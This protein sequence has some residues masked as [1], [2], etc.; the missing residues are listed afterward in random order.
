MEAYF[1]IG[2]ESCGEYE[3]KRSRFLAVAVPCSSEEEVSAKLSE[4]RSKHWDARH[5]VYAYIL[6]NGTS[7]FSDDG[8]PHGTAGK[9]VF[10]VLS[11]SGLTDVLIV[12]TRYF[13]GVLLG[14]GGLVRAYSASAKAAL[15]TAERVK[16]CPCISFEITCPYTDHQRLTRL[17]SDHNANIIDTIFAADVTLQFT[18]QYEDKTKFLSSLTETFAARL[19]AKEG[20]CKFAPIFLK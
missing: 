20:E 5:N 1:T 15:D 12:V 9:P 4:I 7:R 6:Q 10:D 3:E 16:M 13:G 2:S 11:G 17:L 8:E 14:T 18:L 19:E